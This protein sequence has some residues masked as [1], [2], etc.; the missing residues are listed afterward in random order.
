M[1]KP[2]E[3]RCDICGSAKHLAGERDKPKKEDQPPKGT[4]K[5]DKGKTDKGKPK[6]REN[7]ETLVKENHK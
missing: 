4:S 7:Q 3:K 5:G 6:D 1:L 2:E